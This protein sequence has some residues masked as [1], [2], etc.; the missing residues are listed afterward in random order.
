MDPK[1]LA[2]IAT[3]S[4]AA[5]VS[6]GDAAGGNPEGR[7]PGAALG[8]ALGGG[9]ARR[10]L[11]EAFAP[12]RASVN[13]SLVLRAML[14]GATA[15]AL[16]GA[17]FVGAAWATHHLAWRGGGLGFV[18]LG[19]LVG[20]AIGARR[21]WND[22]AVALYVDGVLGTPE[23]VT[24]AVELGREAPADVIEGA[25]EALR[26]SGPRPPRRLR[27]RH[28][29]ALLGTAACI[30]ALALRPPKPAQASPPTG[31]ELVK[32][33][34]V[35]GLDKIAEVEKL[36]A[37]DDAQRKRLEEIA[38]DARELKKKLLEGMP[39][40]EALDQLRK[41][42]QRLEAE[43]QEL[44]GGERKPGLDAAAS[45]L[46]NEGFPG[47]ADA[48]EERDLQSF[49]EMMERLA[50]DREEKDREKAKDALDKAIAEA[51]KKGA[52]DVAKELQ[53]QKERLEKR[54]QQGDA[55]RDLADALKGTPGDPGKS[56]KDYEQKGT[57]ESSR[58]LADS[59]RKGLE[60]LS[61]EE[62]K[63]LAERL[64]KEAERGGPD[65][66][67]SPGGKK[68]MKDL[69]DKLKSPEGQKELEKQ[70]RDYANG[71]DAD[72]D[73]TDEEK[74]QQGLGD[75]EDGAD[76][77]EKGLGDKD[78]KGKDGKGKGKGKGKGD[79]GDGKGDGKG[80]KGDGKG[81]GK[82][83]KGDGDGD[84][85][86]DGKG[87][88]KKPGDG[89]GGGNGMGIDIGSGAGGPGPGGG[90]GDHAGKSKKLD[91]ETLKARARGVNGATGAPKPGGWTERSAGN[92]GSKTTVKGTGDLGAA[93][94][95]DVNG[96]DRAEVPEGV[97]RQV[98]SYFE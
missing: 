23:T 65:G 70:L 42:Q 59:L 52:D 27:R 94:A 6:E 9:A 90:K 56:L 55:L 28:S 67:M 85:D 61:P 64:E 43:R 39:R 69:A 53:K 20:A 24:S 36:P 14:D 75:G 33:S 41:L 73:Q 11:D 72:K 63:K 12:W 58:D 1:R 31:T 50:N 29:L 2:A 98:K 51:K 95:S 81:D 88:G 48:L 21:T 22:R 34:E 38:K 91:A 32:L 4:S 54:G 77:A 25:I 49:D 10:E 18:A 96:V 74:R 13:R 16:G 82:G 60:K 93:G 17:A 71:G 86:G 8:S 80:D 35:P 46:K 7:G 84:G 3:D 68:R 44:G 62:R 19:A 97:R 87:D 40:R 79:K 37:K 15:G 5:D 78:G 30:A 57:D 76:D 47:L 92:D 26:G 45:A 89:N 83:D 66:K